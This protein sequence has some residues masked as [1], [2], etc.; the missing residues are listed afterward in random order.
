M[1][2][3]SIWE[4]F[5]S[6]G[7]VWENVKRFRRAVKG[8]ESSITFGGRLAK[9]RNLCKHNKKKLYKI[10]SL[11]CPRHT[12]IFS[13]FTN[14]II[15]YFQKKRRTHLDKFQKTS[16]SVSTSQTPD[17]AFCKAQGSA[18]LSCFSA[19]IFPIFV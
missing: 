3:R 2:C 19:P 17:R 16:L 7:I 1:F 13:F 5:S 12:H 9:D 4:R 15:T 14:S 11:W 6:I 8:L 10:L 18:E